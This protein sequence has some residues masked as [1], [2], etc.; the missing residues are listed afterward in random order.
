VKL[1]AAMEPL[2]RVPAWL[3]RGLRAFW[4]YI[5]PTAAERTAWTLTLILVGMGLWL[6]AKGYLYSQTGLWLDEASWA[7]RIFDRPLVQS[8]IRPIGFL[9]VSKFL[10]S[11]FSNTETVLRALPWTA[12]V[13][14]TLIA[15]LLARRLYASP[16]A[17]VLFVA[18]IALSPYAIDFSKEFKPYS[19]SLALHL[20]VMLLTHRYSTTER[21]RDLAK[22][23]TL[24]GIGSFF[25]QDLVLAFPGAFLVMGLTALKGRQQRHLI[26]TGIVATLII[27]GLAL[28]YYVMWRNLPPD[29]A[30]FWGNKYNVFHTPQDPQ[31]YLAWA[32]DRYQDVV[33]MPGVRR[34]LWIA[35][36]LSP[37]ARQR[38]RNA[39][40]VMWV[41]LHVAGLLTLAYQRR[42]RDALLVFMPLL[43]LLAFNRAGFWPLGLFRTNVFAVAY[44]G[45]IAAMAVDGRSGRTSVWRAVCPALLLV[46]LPLAVFERRWH[47]HK[48]SGTYDSTFP[49]AI[50]FLINTRP[51][52]PTAPPEIVILDRRS[53][54]PWRYYTKYHP[55]VRQ[56]A[57]A[58]IQRKYVVK[59][60]LNDDDLPRD[61]LQGA[62]LGRRTWTVLHV[63]R[64]F[65]TMM[66]RGK[67]GS[68]RAIQRNDVGSHTVIA[69]TPVPAGKR[70]TLREPPP[71]TEPSSDE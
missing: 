38:L 40:E 14:A 36:W 34:T 66:R 68:L 59:C 30:E 28:Q 31:G 2:K 18:A 55:K 62:V 65:D 51:L 64:P 67:F 12:G 10:A 35:D 46:F 44:T 24:A 39:D 27:L 41:L 49:R 16:G 22:A 52:S 70:P 71:D 57:A 48:Q 58:D 26:A 15:P 3:W 69:L 61:L 56:R 6:R 23:L 53:C 17:R 33:A 21:G 9:A 63:T 1:V 5:G 7:M 25:A 47:A 43:V 50:D 32:L 45:A 20:G 19:L 60:S 29:H 13:A 11:T 4:L 42:L 37:S 8:L 54:D